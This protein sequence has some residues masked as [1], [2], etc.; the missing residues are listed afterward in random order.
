ML[1][2]E[3]VTSTD[4]GRIRAVIFSLSSQE[5][6]REL[7]WQT[8]SPPTTPLP[9]VLLHNAR[10]HRFRWGRLSSSAGHFSSYL[11][12]PVRLSAAPFPPQLP[13]AVETMLPTLRLQSLINF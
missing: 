10:Q 5:G 8:T 1:C 3:A 9:Q 4:S 11:S 12:R 7:A 2:T 6:R 13:H